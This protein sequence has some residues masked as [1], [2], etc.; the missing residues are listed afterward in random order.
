MHAMDITEYGQKY[1]GI[2]IKFTKQNV[3]GIV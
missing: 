2:E 3:E 1:R